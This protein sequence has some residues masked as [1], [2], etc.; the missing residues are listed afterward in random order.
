MTSCPA[1]FLQSLGFT[2]KITLLLIWQA[3]NPNIWTF[4]SNDATDQLGR[5]GPLQSYF[6][7]PP[8]RRF[9]KGEV[10]LI[11]LDS[12]NTTDK[13]NLIEFTRE[14]NLND[15]LCVIVK[16]ELSYICANVFL[17]YEYVLMTA[18]AW[19]SRDE[20]FL[21]VNEYRQTSRKTIV[22]SVRILNWG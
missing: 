11:I 19:L 8:L 6:H 3:E 18:I 16:I 9:H 14:W 7:F 2:L 22:W 17:P 4:L 13:A 20:Y 1:S 12:E 5:W 10:R 21:G 15:W